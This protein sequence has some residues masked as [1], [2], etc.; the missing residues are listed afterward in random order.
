MQNVPHRHEKF[1]HFII[2]CVAIMAAL[3]PIAAFAQGEDNPTGVTG[4][5]NGNVTTAGSYDPLTFNAIRAIDDIVVP[6]SVGAYPLKWTRYFNTR[7]APGVSHWTY[8][9]ND[10]LIGSVTLGGS[11]TIGFPDGRRINLADACVSG[12]EEFDVTYAGGA[13]LFLADGG[14]VTFQSF[15]S[16]VEDPILH[17]PVCSTNYMPIAMTDPYGQVT[18]ITQAI[19]DY[20]YVGH[21]LYHIDTIADSTGR[22]LK[23]NWQ[24]TSNPDP[25]PGDPE[26][27]ISSVQA[28]AGV[29]A[30]PIQS[31]N[32]SWT[33]YQ[34][35]GGSNY[36]T[37]LDHVNYSDGTTAHYTYAKPGDH[38]TLHTAEDVRYNGPMRQIEYAYDSTGKIVAE[39]NFN[40]H[41]AVSSIDY[42][43]STGYQR[44]ETRGDG[45]TRTFTYV[46]GGKDQEGTCVNGSPVAEN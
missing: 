8:S 19:Y 39:K 2:F 6:G 12:V 32:Y 46:K 15:Q 11:D 31:V 17:I 35:P 36:F 10:Y 3:L 22:Y 16:C 29:N 9:Y 42:L 14:Q 13:T 37:V 23:I 21:P 25:G 30:Q 1:S 20:D 41:E 5:Y 24:Q 26:Y 40:T 33:L 38:V 43:G 4:I 7:K 34:P 44:T 28:F 27:V 18:T 45:A